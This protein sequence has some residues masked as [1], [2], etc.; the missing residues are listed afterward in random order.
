VEGK[1]NTVKVRQW[2]AEKAR[3]QEEVSL[4]SE[5]EEAEFVGEESV[6]VYPKTLPKSPQ[7][8]RIASFAY[9]I[10]APNNVQTFPVSQEIRDLGIDFGIIVLRIKNNWGRKEFTCL[11]R[12]RVHGQRMGAS[13]E[14]P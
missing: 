1:D 4:R 7:Y 2:Q 9:D 8:I 13:E 12:L 5:K 11:Y 14:L 3:R 6:E 10:N